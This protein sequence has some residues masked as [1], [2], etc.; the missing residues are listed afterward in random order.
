MMTQNSNST[1]PFQPGDSL[2]GEFFNLPG[3]IQKFTGCVHEITGEL[4]TLK[5]LE[6][7]MT[8]NIKPGTELTLIYEHHTD[9]EAEIEKYISYFIKSNPLFPKQITIAKPEPIQS[10]TSRRFFRCDVS[11]PFHYFHQQFKYI[12]TVTNLSASG[13]YA[14]IPPN[15]DL[16]PGMTIPIQFRLPSVSGHFSLVA[17]VIRIQILNNNRWGVALNFLNASESIQSEIVQYLFRRQ[18]DLNRHQKFITLPERETPR[19]TPKQST[20]ENTFFSEITEGFQVPRERTQLHEEVYPG[21]VGSDSERVPYDTVNSG[22][23]ASVQAAPAEPSTAFDIPRQ[24]P[25][26][27]GFFGRVMAFLTDTLFLVIGL[28]VITG[29]TGMAFGILNQPDASGN[30]GDILAT[31]RP[32]LIGFGGVVGLALYWIY[33]SVSESSRHQGTVGKRLLKIQVADLQGQ[34]ISFGMA[35]KRS[36]LKILSAALLG[37]GFLMAVFNRN[38]QCLHDLLAHTTVIHRGVPAPGIETNPG[39]KK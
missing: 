29:L 37:I 39:I 24:K 35:G 19:N 4:M 11:L 26:Y 38:H 12:G 17:E 28:S 3:Q 6:A 9:S 7:E 8:E 20:R 13:L 16:G 32:F 21:E 22:T 5:L 25:Y 14:V 33:F 36:L 27:A 2:H 18:Q 23:A 30:L 1:S 34:R 15:Q 10:E 31:A